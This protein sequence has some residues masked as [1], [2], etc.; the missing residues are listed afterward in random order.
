M[1]F[2][3]GNDWPRRTLSRS[4]YP[5][6]APAER[7]AIPMGLP[8]QGSFAYTGGRY[9]EKSRRL[10]EESPVAGT[11]SVTWNGMDDMGNHISTCIYLYQLRAGRYAEMKKMLLLDCS[12]GSHMVKPSMNSGTQS[13]KLD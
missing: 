10:L 4:Q 3:G 2:S 11:H 8:A 9:T 13:V 1:K 5:P 6:A 12:G 7:M